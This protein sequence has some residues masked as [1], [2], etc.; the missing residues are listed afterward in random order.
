MNSEEGSAPDA[1]M[2]AIA[3]VQQAV[4]ASP[5]DAELRIQ[6]ICLILGAGLAD[7]AQKTGL[8]A[9]CSSVRYFPL[10]K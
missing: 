3:A 4:D 5:L 2:V 6:L 8:A 7:R 9:V 1:Q 10:K